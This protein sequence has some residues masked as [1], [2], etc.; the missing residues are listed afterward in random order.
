MN[1][2]YLGFLLSLLSTVINGQNPDFEW[3]KSMGGTMNDYGNSIITDAN[4]NIY[5]TGTYQDSV[6]FDPNTNDFYLHSSGFGDVFIQKLDEDGNFMW[7]KSM[8]EIAGDIGYSVTIDALGNLYLTGVY[9]GTV[10]FDP[11]PDT[12][13]LNSNGDKDGFVVKL[14]TA[15]NL[16]WQGNR[17]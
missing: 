12:F 17:I 2:I 8:G 10:D 16:I 15:G 13:N 11:G 4:S 3:A 14:D 9:E 5:L 7:A 1:K 6:Y